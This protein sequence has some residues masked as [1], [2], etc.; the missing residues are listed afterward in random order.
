M[1]SCLIASS[2]QQEDIQQQLTSLDGAE[3]ASDSDPESANEI[4]EPTANR[5]MPYSFAYDTGLTSGLQLTRKESGDESGVR[6]S[7]SYIDAEGLFRTVEYVADKDGFRAVIKTNEPGLNDAEKP[8]PAAVT[9][10]GEESPAVVMDRM[11]GRSPPT[12]QSPP[13]PGPSPAPLP[14]QA[15]F[16]SRTQKVPASQFVL[17]EPQRS[18]LR[19]L[20]EQNPGARMFRLIPMASGEGKTAPRASNLVLL[21]PEQDFEE[22]V[23]QQQQQQ[24]ETVEDQEIDEKVVKLPDVSK[25]CLSSILLIGE[26]SQITLANRPVSDKDVRDSVEICLPRFSRLRSL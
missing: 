14:S 19:N 7:Y 11:H 17:F 20:A 1:L 18:N 23:Q 24:E 16:Q 2:L 21:L 12:T 3:T 5:M 26:S 15:S 9:I 8:R 13:T 22:P 10:H 4:K 6:G 25:L